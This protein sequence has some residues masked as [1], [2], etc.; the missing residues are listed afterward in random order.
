MSAFTVLEIYYPACNFTNGFCGW[1]ND[2]QPAW[3]I[4]NSTVKHVGRLTGKQGTFLSQ[5]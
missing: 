1:D 5:Y 4:V 2:R 3:I